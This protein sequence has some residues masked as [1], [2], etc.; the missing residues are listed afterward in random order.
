VAEPI[1]HHVD[2]TLRAQ[3]LVHV[4]TTV[5]ADVAA[6]ARVV[7]PTWT[8]G[9]YVVRDYVHHVQRVEATDAAGAPVR[10]EPDGV[11][12]WR[13]PA[14]VE[15]PVE[16]HLEL[17]AN[18]LTVRTNHVDDRHALLVP[19][20]TFP[21]V[22]GATD[23]PHHVS[24][25]PAAAG[26]APGSGTVHSLLPPGDEP[27]T[28]VADD[29]DHLVDAA[30][31]VGDHEVVEFEVA[32]VPHRFVHAAAGPAPDLDRVAADARA[33][34]EA[35]VELFGGDLP[36]ERYTFLH[37][38]DDAA[39]GGGGLEH[40]DGSVLQMP[41]F[42][43]HDP[44][45][46][47]RLQ[48]LVAHEYLHLWNV[49]RLVPAG[50]LDL[51]Y[52][53]PTHTTSLWVA[54]GWTAYYDELL[55]TRAGLWTLRRYLDHLRDG[56]RA[57]VDTPGT[58][59]QSVQESSYHAWTGLYVRDENSVN[60]GT[61]YYGH[62]ALLAWCLDLA[63]RRARPDG[64]G[65]DDALRLLWERFGR[66]GTGYTEQ[67][68][69]DALEEAAGG[70]STVRS[71][72]DAHV[73]G[74]DLPDLPSLL[75]AVGLRLVDEDG[76]GPQPAT[77]L[78]V[79]TSED[80]QGVVFTSVLRDRAAWRAGITGGD[81]LLAIDG[82]RVGRG[83]LAAALRGHQPGSVVD[84]TVF[85]GVRLRTL[86]VTLDPP[87]VTQRLTA[88]EAPSESQQEAFR[89]WTGRPLADA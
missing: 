55:P 18:E 43:W 65:L 77:S 78:G 80:D 31:E 63:I 58:A 62:G 14:D 54:E 46:Y 1:R 52:E 49:K 86:A 32:G 60:K 11:T 64:D 23:R 17:Y 7:L 20:A 26:Q 72:V 16:F 59:N 42:T 36:V 88:V 48:S 19:A 41:V 66:T 35:A 30:F 84:V 45:A 12:A 33:V 83:E 34:A 28:F 8:P 53:R 5:P 37:E 39:A 75:D 40:R 81:R 56:W 9:S 76:S 71:L 70:A 15:G 89:R 10:L 74:R 51:D 50:L 4:T 13:L 73:V 2:L 57:V 68:V 21:Y 22:E 69:V 47:A 87:A 44:D 61:S 3:H 24:F 85:S 38:G 27:R 67:D 82:L 79:Q 29:L 6:G 25:A